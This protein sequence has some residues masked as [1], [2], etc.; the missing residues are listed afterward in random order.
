VTKRR[1]LDLLAPYS[2]DQYVYVRCHMADGPFEAVR[3]LIQGVAPNPPAHGPGPAMV[4]IDVHERNRELK[5][6]V[7]DR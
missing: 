7:P 5:P 1:L 4:G 6:A 2:D 3:L